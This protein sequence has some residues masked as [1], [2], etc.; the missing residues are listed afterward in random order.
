MDQSSKRTNPS[1]DPALSAFLHIHIWGSSLASPAHVSSLPFLLETTSPPSRPQN[2]M[3]TCHSARPSTEHPRCCLL[4]LNVDQLKG[5]IASDEALLRTIT[6]LEA[7]AKKTA[8][9]ASRAVQEAQSALLAAHAWLSS[10]VATYE[11][12]R[13]EAQRIAAMV[14]KS[15]RLLAWTPA[16]LPDDLIVYIAAMCVE[17]ERDAV[18]RRWPEFGLASRSA[19]KEESSTRPML[20]S[21]W[22]LY[23]MAIS[24]VCQR[25]RTAALG[26]PRLWAYKDNLG[27]IKSNALL[28]L[29]SLRSGLCEIDVLWNLNAQVPT[30]DP[31]IEMAR[32]LD[33]VLPSK[34]VHPYPFSTH[35]SALTSLSIRAASPERPSTFSASHLL[36][37]PNLTKLELVNVQLLAPPPHRHAPLMDLTIRYSGVISFRAKD[38]E[39]ISIVFPRLRKF[40]LYIRG[41][42]INKPPSPVSPTD[43][44][45]VPYSFPDLEYLDINSKDLSHSLSRFQGAFL[46]KLSSLR[47]RDNVLPSAT[48]FFHHLVRSRVPLTT[49]GLTDFT[50]PGIK[51]FCGNRGIETLMVELCMP[52][53]DALRPTSLV[54]SPPTSPLSPVTTLPPNVLADLT[55]TFPKVT[56]VIILPPPAAIEGSL[57]RIEAVVLTSLA[58][59]IRERNVAVLGPRVEST[60]PTKPSMSPT[61]GDG[62]STK[63]KRKM[64]SAEM[65]GVGFGKAATNKDQEGIPMKSDDTL[66]ESTAPSSPSG[67]SSV[68]TAFPPPPS[69]TLNMLTKPLPH[70]PARWTQTFG[71]SSRPRRGT[72]SS[73]A[74][75]PIFEVEYT[76]NRG[77]GKI[78]LE[79]VYAALVD[80]RQRWMEIGMGA[81]KA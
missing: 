58:H 69:S 20:G 50:S 11:S 33:L 37:M 72:V 35:S 75:L 46:P 27:G 66:V 15:R 60:S 55:L 53:V 59:A 14:A 4:S 77:R 39:D 80:G 56:K 5:R 8:S 44:P 32:T 36:Q 40:S 76:P 24:Q 79:E 2:A 9:N 64:S 25:W 29:I 62:E 81:W 18:R 51:A 38:M 45:P 31:R 49:L 34:N 13:Q 65:S 63:A 70:V 78:A 52:A 71:T 41:P 28:D 12:Y 17:E 3:A 67:T 54:P 19:R 73:L 21:I 10:A 22:W 6:D 68:L 26:S 43:Q 16:L 30:V 57:G 61:R 42:Y 47:L 74:A 1:S 23:P 7:S 48:T